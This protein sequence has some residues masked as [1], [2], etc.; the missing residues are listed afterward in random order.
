MRRILVYVWVGHHHLA[1]EAMYLA[2]RKLFRGYELIPHGDSGR[3]VSDDINADIT[4][5]GGGDVLPNWMMASKVRKSK[6]NYCLGVGVL[7]ANF[8]NRSW[9]KTEPKNILENI[10]DRV[11]R[12]EFL[13]KIVKLACS[14]R[15]GDPL[16]LKPYFKRFH[17]S[18]RDFQR[19]AKFGF[20]RI[21]VR[22]PV[23]Q[24]ILRQHGI[25]STIVGDTALYCEPTA[26]HYEKSYKVG[27]NVTRPEYIEQWTQDDAHIKHI[28]SFCNSISDKYRFVILPF[29]PLDLEINQRLS[30]EINNAIL[31]DFYTTDDVQGAI[32]EISTC[33]LMIAERFHATSFSACCHVP[34]ISL[35]YQPK[36]LDLVRSLDLEELNIRTD[37]VTYEKLEELF[38]KAIDNQAIINRLRRNVENIRKKLE[39]FAAL[40]KTDIEHVLRV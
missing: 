3:A 2:V 28:I 4:L 32:D 5:F 27:I 34:F 25:A 7:D 11:D 19:I 6:L 38:N 20:D 24:E 18:E 15:L 12:S 35:E 39:D 10:F 1:D 26:Y 14:T 36:K 40:I 16:K 31:L 37:Q 13:A 33:D 23:S 9:D 22:G 8:F 29:Y 17:I 30:R 21:G